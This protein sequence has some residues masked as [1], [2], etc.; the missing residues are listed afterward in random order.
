M[1]SQLKD[2]VFNKAGTPYLVL[3]RDPESQDWLWV[4][5][6]NAERTVLRMHRDEIVASLENPGPARAQRR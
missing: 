6:I 3:H 4:K 5:A 1:H 2:Q